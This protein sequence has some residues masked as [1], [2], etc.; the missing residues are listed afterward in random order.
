MPKLDLNSIPE[1]KGTN[2]PEQFAG[3]CWAVSASASATL[4]A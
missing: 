1:R 4:P 2:Y 3:L